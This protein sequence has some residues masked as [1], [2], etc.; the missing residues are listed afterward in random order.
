MLHFSKH[1][2]NDPGKNLTIIIGGR[3][4]AIKVMKGKYDE[5]KE[6]SFNDCIIRGFS[7]GWMYW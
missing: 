6:F 5:E 3:F 2:C 1:T 4:K 7:H